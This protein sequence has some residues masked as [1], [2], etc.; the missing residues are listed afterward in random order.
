MEACTFSVST[1]AR[2]ALTTA[3]AS[4]AEVLRAGGIAAVEGAWAGGAELA[5][6]P[7][8]KTDGDVK[9]FAEESGLAAIPEGEAD[10]AVEVWLEGLMA[11]EADTEAASEGLAVSVAV[12]LQLTSNV[13]AAIE[14]RVL[15]G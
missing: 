11:T 8:G 15:I 2:L 14:K 9:V 13:V 1:A 10:G 12:W 5:V 6:I 7:E 3:T 4:S